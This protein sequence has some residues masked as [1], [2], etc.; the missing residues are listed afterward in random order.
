MIVLREWDQHGVT[1]APLGGAPVRL[2]V[3]DVIESAPA[4]LD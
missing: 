3:D 1:V 4:H 2:S